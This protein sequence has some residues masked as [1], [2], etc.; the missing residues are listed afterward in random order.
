MGRGN[1]RFY[2]LL[3]LPK[4]TKQLISWFV[5]LKQQMINHPEQ[6]KKK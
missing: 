2:R 3:K 6:K 5:K 4:E 1:N